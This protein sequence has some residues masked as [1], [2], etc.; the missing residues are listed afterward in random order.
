MLEIQK[1]LTCLKR[2]VLEAIVVKEQI[3]KSSAEAACML[4]RMM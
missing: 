4:V 2:D 3:V 1:L